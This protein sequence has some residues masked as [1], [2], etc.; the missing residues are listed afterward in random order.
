MWRGKASR[1]AVFIAG[2]AT[3]GMGAY[4]FFLPHLFGWERFTHP[5]P[6][7]IQWALSAI[8][9]FLSFFL[10]AGGLS[11]AAAACYARHG[12]AGLI[13]TMLSFWAFNAVYQLA[14]PFPTPGVR[15]LLLAFALLVTLLYAAGLLALRRGTE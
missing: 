2:T 7:E 14:W 6:V 11:S 12:A 13:W 8:N 4:H 10:L 15:W 1:V 5:L 9:A 3:A